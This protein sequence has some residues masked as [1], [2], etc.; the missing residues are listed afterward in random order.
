MGSTENMAAAWRGGFS[1]ES[2]F[3]NDQDLRSKISSAMGF[4]FA[5][6]FSDP[7][8]LV[9]GG[10]TS[11]NCNTPGLWNTNWFANVRRRVLPSVR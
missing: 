7:S 1:N 6:D 5:N 10:Q 2:Q 11:C 9:A 4:W 3:T 8:C